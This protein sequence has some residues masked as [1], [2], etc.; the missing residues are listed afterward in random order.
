MFI[1]VEAY[2]VIGWTA[3]KQ[4]GNLAKALD[5][6]TGIAADLEFEIAMAV[7]RNDGFQTFGQSVIDPAGQV[8]LGN[9]VCHADRMAHINPLGR[10]HGAQMSGDVGAIQIRRGGS[11]DTRQIAVNGLKDRLPL[12]PAKRIEHGAIHQSRAI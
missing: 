4:F 10:W 9:R 1:A 12:R 7:A 3:I 6:S 5:V 2:T 11:V 8:S